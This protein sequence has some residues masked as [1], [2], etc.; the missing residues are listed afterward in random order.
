VTSGGL[1]WSLASGEVGGPFAKETYIL[2]AN[3]TAIAAQVTVEV[4]FGDGQTTQ[5]AF[6]V[7]AETRINVAV[8]SAFPGFVHPGTEKRRFGAVV[9]S[10]NGVSVVVEEA[11]YSNAV[12]GDGRF[13]SAGAGAAAKLL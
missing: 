13:W 1:K 10:T 6:N 7:P 4:L 12:P 3:P 8:S 9:T 2:I 5:Q 11:I